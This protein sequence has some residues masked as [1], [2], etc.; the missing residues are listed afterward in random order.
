[1]ACWPQIWSSLFPSW[2]AGCSV[3]DAHNPHP[4][5]VASKNKVFLCLAVLLGVFLL[6]N[7]GGGDDQSGTPATPPPAPAPALDWDYVALGDSLAF[8]VAAQ[9]GYVPRYA[10]FIRSDTRAN[11][12]VTNF[13][14]PGWTSA[15]LLDAL[16]NNAAI[17]NVV[18]NAEVV[19]FDIGGNDLLSA[20]RRFLDGSCGG[21]ENLDCFRI[22]VDEFKNNWDGILVEILALRSRDAT[23]LRTMDVYNP[24]VAEQKALGIFDRLKPYLD[25]VNLHIAST[26]TTAGIPYARVYAAFNGP[27]GEEDAVAKGYIAADLVHAND[28]GHMV[29]AE[30]LRATGY[31]PLH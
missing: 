4:M 20:R 25:E 19:T 11:L 14:V 28:L 1:V 29:M 30:A 5:K 9:Q 23:V 31:A 22:T 12:R 3:L 15:D 26:A 7:C 2:H 16:R 27:N 18:M 8:G 21:P 24:F 13:G 6:S 10:E 17:R